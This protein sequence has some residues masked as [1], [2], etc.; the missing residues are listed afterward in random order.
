MYTTPGASLP[1]SIGIPAPFPG[2]LIS[3][4]RGQ[5]HIFLERL[6][7]DWRQRKKNVFVG[8][9]ANRGEKME[10][11][12]DWEEEEMEET[13]AANLQ[14]MPERTREEARAFDV[15]FDQVVHGKSDTVSH[16]PF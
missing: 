13:E 3:R 4:R 10:A 15:F 12:S 8:V 1:S 16:W 7:R 9:C 2:C 11:A 14:E 6:D 5:D